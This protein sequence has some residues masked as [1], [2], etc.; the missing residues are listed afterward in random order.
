MHAWDGIWDKEILTQTKKPHAERPRLHVGGQVIK[1]KKASSNEGSKIS[2]AC[3]ST[4]PPPNQR[5]FPSMDFTEGK[6]ESMYFNICLDISSLLSLV[7]RNWLGCLD[8]KYVPPSIVKGFITRSTN[9]LYFL[10]AIY[11]SATSPLFF[12]FRRVLSS[13]SGTHHIRATWSAGKFLFTE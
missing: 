13:W 7:C 9:K 2:H 6:L 3:K 5:S 12:S 1:I 4:F 10:L 8:Y 11:F